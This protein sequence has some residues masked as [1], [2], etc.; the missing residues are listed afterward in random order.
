MLAATRPADS[1]ACRES[2]WTGLASDGEASSE[3]CFC[4][5][6]TGDNFERTH[7]FPIFGLV[8]RRHIR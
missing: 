5:L 2:Q 8:P 1:R 4:Q 7:R 3:F 6:L